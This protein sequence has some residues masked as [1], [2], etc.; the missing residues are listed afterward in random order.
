MRRGDQM[1]TRF[2]PSPTGPLH[3]GH[4]YSALTV[5]KIAADLGGTALLRIEDTDS[6][7][8]RPVFEQS[9]YDDLAWLGLSWPMPVLRQS[10]HKAD[11]DAALSQLNALGLIYPCGCTR[12]DVITAGA[13]QG[14]DGM[15]YP[16]TCRGRSMIDAL[17]ADAVRL[18]V[19]KAIKLLA[20]PLV[21][22]ETGHCAGHV[23]VDPNG[24]LNDI[25]D[26]V[27]RRKD[28]GDL[29]YHLACVYDD[30]RQKVSHVVRGIDLQALTPLHVLLQSILQLPTPIYHHHPLILDEDGKR[31][32]KIDK[33]KALGKF[34]TEGITP[35]E[36]R[37]II[38][39]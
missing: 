15:V 13:R 3:L 27:L 26:P 22:T 4:A 28:T 6:T 35:K 8:V 38:G 18:D 9:I 10:D 23:A 11:Y 2:A 21:F 16:G 25:G 32:A 1:I 24:L 37:A 5:W 31:L 17:P 7:R 34:R 36:I 20:A 29:A 30:A 39:L 33:S 12:R 14:L 19:E